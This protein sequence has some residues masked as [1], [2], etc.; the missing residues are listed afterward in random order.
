MSAWLKH[1]T[2]LIRHIPSPKQYTKCV[3]T[4]MDGTLID[5]KSGRVHPK[6]SDD[7]IWR[8]GVLP[9]L[10]NLSRDTLIVIM[11]NQRGAGR[12]DTKA[13]DIMKKIDN[14]ISELSRDVVAILA[15]GDD[16]Y[17]KPAIGMMTY[18]CQHYPYHDM[19]NIAYIGDAAGRTSD[20]SCSDRKFAS[21]IGITFHTPEE[22]FLGERPHSWSWGWSPSEYLKTISSYED[23]DI[24]C[25]SKNQEMVILIG[26]PASGKSYIAQHTFPS[27]VRVNRDTLGTMS[28]CYQETRNAISKG[29]SVVIDNTNP[30]QKSRQPFVDIASAANIPIRYIVVDVSDDLVCHNNR[31]RAVV[32]GDRDV[33]PI[34]ALR[35]FRKY[36]EKPPDAHVI[37]FLPRFKDDHDMMIW[38]MWYD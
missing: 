15:T 20:F 34:V 1:E 26:P 33:V 14:M 19:D 36:Y 28:K 22:Y 16:K 2:I 4:D 8:H 31:Y 21:N 5:T 7:W 27:Y 24:I 30:S 17:R 25:E 10:K 35:T 11:S 32:H 13:N 38:C 9:Y 18:F 3:Y 29:Q 23:H 12:D 37:P 6:S